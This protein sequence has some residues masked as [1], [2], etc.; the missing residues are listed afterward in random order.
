M[1]CTKRTMEFIILKIIAIT[2]FPEFTLSSYLHQDE[3]NKDYK[4]M[5]AVFNKIFVNIHIYIHT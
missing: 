1:I 4:E 3:I 2:E 5:A